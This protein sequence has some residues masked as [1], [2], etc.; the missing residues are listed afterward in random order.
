MSSH[1]LYVGVFLAVAFLSCAPAAAAGQHDPAD[2]AIVDTFQAYCAQGGGELGW[3]CGTGEQTLS[4]AHKY[5]ILNG[6]CTRDK[7][8]G[9][10]APAAA[11]CDGFGQLQ[12]PPVIEFDVA[13][14]R[15][16]ARGGFEIRR[17]RV[18]IDSLAGLP[19]AYLGKRGNISVVIL[20][21]P[22]TLDVNRGAT[23][24][25][26][27]PQ[28]AM[29]EKLLESAAMFAGGLPSA[30][31]FTARAAKTS[32]TGGERTFSMSSHPALPHGMEADAVE[33]DT[34]GMDD[35]LAYQADL[36]LAKD[37]V[38]S[39]NDG[40]RPLKA[41]LRKLRGAERTFRLL[42]QRL[43]SAPASFD[44]SLLA[45]TLEDPVGW[46]A[47]FGQVAN[48]IGDL[49]PV[50]AWAPFFEK[51]A[52]GLSADP[53]KP[54]AVYEAVTRALDAQPDLT[55]CDP[56]CADSEYRARVADTLTSVG[57]A[58]LE[59][60][61]DARNASAQSAL[62]SALADARDRHLLHA[63]ALTR[64]FQTV[65]KVE[66]TL[67]E[68]LSQEDATR[69][70][71]M[72][73]ASISARA[74]ASATSRPAPGVVRVDRKIYVPDEVFL[75]SWTK[76]R[77]YPLVIAVPTSAGDVVFSTLPKET[78]TS[79]RLARKAA[80]RVSIGA[81]LI[82]TPAHSSVYG[83]VDPTPGVTTTVSDTTKRGDAGSGTSGTTTVAQLEPKQIIETDRQ[84]RAGTIGLFL[85][86]RAV[87]TED[88]GAG[89]Q[90]GF[91]TSD[92]ALLVGP[93]LNLSRYLTF[94]GGAGFFR[95]KRLG[96]DLGGREQR[97]GDIVY[98]GDELR[99][100]DAWIWSFYF[101]LSAN[102]SGL[103]LFKK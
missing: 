17:I 2:R 15:W 12:P 70:A 7:V 29:L 25:T 88:L 87:G 44:P 63:L 31:A 99:S 22:M 89:V 76:I 56:A 1:R 10:P 8:A 52:A 41:Q 38:K 71:G 62:R 49:T 86:Y 34:T 57:R 5:D 51:A 45:P 50:A 46:S 61:R 18:E 4:L 80:S 47:L 24:E 27:A 21:N 26:N 81:G 6:Y 19:L 14:R 72:R 3:F 92:P 103:P 97:P 55:A 69:T 82:Y 66:E 73:L 102:V 94:S 53:A 67:T 32:A 91:G 77:E 93:V 54:Q 37:H 68:A 42:A 20:G 90:L 40:A 48:T 30:A 43:E 74:R 13:T 16:S 100:R 83:V 78:K 101:S 36:L 96:H 9:L 35:W 75:A 28:V 95:V 33:V 23:T 65:T 60:S 98:S 84:S 85:N 58:A 79:Y 59:A 11:V 64:A 39:L